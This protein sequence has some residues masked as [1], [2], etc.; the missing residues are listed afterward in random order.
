VPVDAVRLLIERGADVNLQG[1]GGVT[2]LHLAKLRGSTAV[3]ALLEKAGAKDE[4]PWARPV[5]TYAPAGSPRDA[6]TRSVPLLQHADTQFLA[7][8]GCVSCHNNTLTAMTV[9]AA[10]TKKIAVDEQVAQTQLKTIGEYIHSWRDRV[11][12]GIGIPG[13]AD[14][15]SYILLG[16]AAEKYPADA[17]TDAMARFLLRQQRADGHWDLLAHRPPIESTPVQVTAMSM[18]ALQ[19]YAPAALRAQYEPAIRRA[20]EWLARAQP[21]ANEERAFRLLGLYWSRADSRIIRAAAKDVLAQQ[22]ADGGWSQ[23]PTLESDAYAT[24]QSL[25]AL[26]ESGTVLPKDRAFNRG[27]SFL[28]N[29]QLADGSW[30]VKSRAL[31]IQPHFESG[32][33]YG[34]DQFISAAATNWAALALTHAATN[35]RRTSNP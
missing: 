13:D 7:K 9:A 6:V 4:T 16:L 3:V 21:R 29:T 14:T 1:P 12:Q 31:P 15:M 2:A 35:A 17:A 8:A 26:A 5:L 18:R 34:K 20:G 10:R 32:F 11:L 30:F 23:L 24:G 28:V 27:V 33:P 22:R 25:F 19:L